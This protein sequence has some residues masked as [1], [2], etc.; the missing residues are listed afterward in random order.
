MWVPTAGLVVCVRHWLYTCVHLSVFLQ[1]CA[2]VYYLFRRV[3]GIT[4][5]A[6]QPLHLPLT[7]R[8]SSPELGLNPAP[9]LPW[10]QQL[11][12]H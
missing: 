6:A 7:H 5:E 2:A 3:G 9:G 10:Q 11:S 12:I 4:V 8:P 1:I